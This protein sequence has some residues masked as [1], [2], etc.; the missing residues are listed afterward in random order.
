MPIAKFALCGLCLSLY[1]H[2]LHQVR[3]VRT[4]KEPSHQTSK[5]VYYTLLKPNYMCN[6]SIFLLGSV[7]A[8][9]L[10][11]CLAHHQVSHGKIAICEELG[12]S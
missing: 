11:I 8:E 2:V 4:T 6:I 3:T 1:M 12:W 5:G 9:Q 7:L 10:Y